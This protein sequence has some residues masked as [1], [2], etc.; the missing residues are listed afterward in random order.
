LPAVPSLFD[1]VKSHSRLGL[2]IHGIYHIQAAIERERIRIDRL[3][4]AIKHLQRTVIPAASADV[5]S[6]RIEHD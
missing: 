2:S 4:E 6:D 3:R 5:L 1:D